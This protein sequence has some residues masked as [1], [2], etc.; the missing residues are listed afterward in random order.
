ML[1]VEEVHPAAPA[2][3]PAKLVE[4]EDISPASEDLLC[5]L[6][7]SGAGLFHLIIKC[8]ARIY[9]AGAHHEGIKILLCRYCECP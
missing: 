9:N 7:W 5:T 3:G 4:I 6:K 8:M 2:T 1:F